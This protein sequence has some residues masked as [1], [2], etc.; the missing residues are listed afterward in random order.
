MGKFLI[1]SSENNDYESN[2][3]EQNIEFKLLKE[4]QDIS[5]LSILIRERLITY[6]EEGSY[7]LC[8]FLDYHNIHNYITWLLHNT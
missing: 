8:E 6:A 1:A 5:D 3:I 2:D 7:P 4:E